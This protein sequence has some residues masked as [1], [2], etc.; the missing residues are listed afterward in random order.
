M[1]RVRICAGSDCIECEAGDGEGVTHIRE[2]I[3]K[4]KAEGHDFFCCGYAEEGARC[5]SISQ[6]TTIKPA[7]EGDGGDDPSSH[8]PDLAHP[9]VVIVT[10][11]HRGEAPQFL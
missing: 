3:E 9:E 10:G 8:R 7:R 5:I 6:I 4:Q 1:A 2:T 11:G